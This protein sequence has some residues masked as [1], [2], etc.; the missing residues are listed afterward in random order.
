MPVGGRDIESAERSRCDAAC[1]LLQP[2]KIAARHWHRWSPTSC[3]STSPLLTSTNAATASQDAV[4]L[5]YIR[6]GSYM[7]SHLNRYEHGR[8]AS[9]PSARCGLEPPAEDSALGS[10]V[11]GRSAGGML[12]AKG[13][14]STIYEPPL[15]PAVARSESEPR[16]RG[17]VGGKIGCRA[18][19][20]K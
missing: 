9:R 10:L 4:G 20:G 1:A 8:G 16:A 5:L 3:S 7:Y 12:P 19:E 2:R 15:I 18:G 17:S 11:A 6:R 14:Y 13:R